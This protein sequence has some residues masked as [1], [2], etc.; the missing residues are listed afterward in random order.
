[1]PGMVKIGQSSRSAAER[2]REVGGSTGVPTPFKVAHEFDTV[3]AEAAIRL[4]KLV[5]RHLRKQRVDPKR[6]FFSVSV[7]R[8]KQVIQEIGDDKH[9]LFVAPQYYQTRSGFVRQI[10][11]IIDDDEPQQKQVVRA[12]QI[13]A[14]QKEKERQERERDIKHMQ[15]VCAVYEKELSDRA[16]RPLLQ[17]INEWFRN[18]GVIISAWLFVAFLALAGIYHGIWF[19]AAAGFGYALWKET[20]KDEQITQN[21]VARY[22]SCRN[23]LI[24][25]TGQII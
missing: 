19:I 2:C 11:E 22:N 21:K 10:Q 1:M 3:S 12:A 18:E 7:D 5:F 4:E 15:N 9:L 6:E 16:N 13:A 24:R 14:T 17:K 23:E 8:A 20:T 25:L